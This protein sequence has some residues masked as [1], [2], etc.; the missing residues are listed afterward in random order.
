MRRSQDW[1]FLP[2]WQVRLCALSVDLPPS[3]PLVASASMGLGTTMRSCDEKLLDPS[4]ATSMI[5]PHNTHDHLRESLH[6][7]DVF[8][9]N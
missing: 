9:S 1:P 4:I 7:L 6:R 8:F 2:S 5:Y 3:N